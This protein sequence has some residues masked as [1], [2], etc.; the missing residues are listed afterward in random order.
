[1][2]SLKSSIL[3]SLISI[4]LLLGCGKN[5]SGPTN[6]PSTNP[7]TTPPVA[8]T[9]QL[10]G[11]SQ[12]NGGSKPDFALTITFTNDIASAI[13]LY[14]SLG[15]QKVFDATFQQI[16]SDSIRID[17]YQYL[18]VDANKRVTTLVTRSDMTNPLNADIHRYTYTYNTEGYLTKK[19]LYVNDAYFYT[20][21]YTYANNLL[22]KCI[23][24]VAG[25]DS[26]KILESDLTYDANTTIKNWLY[27]F[28]DAFESYLYNPALN[29]GNKGNKALSQ[30]ITKIYNPVSGTVIDTWTTNYSN[31]VIS[32]DGY[33]QSGTA[34][35]DLQQGMASFYG[36]TTFYYQCK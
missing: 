19:D 3:F 31:Y 14:D 24:T 18:K 28:P 1:M 27:T 17:Q 34:N 32:A 8:K 9:C 5:G 11:I 7:P 33:I 20:T 10:L 16:T 21:N 36:K 30:I 23:M 6:P 35:G 4:T 2:Q 25:N 15:N 12:L 29:F 26:Y 13:L 22:I